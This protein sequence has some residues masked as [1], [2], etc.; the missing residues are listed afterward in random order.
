MSEAPGAQAGQGFADPLF[1]EEDRLG[2]A[3]VA[4]LCNPGEAGALPALE[5][6]LS[7]LAQLY[8]RP[9]R[10]TLVEQIFYLGRKPVRLDI[11]AYKQAQALRAQWSALGFG[12]MIFPRKITAEG[13]KVFLGQVVETLAN[14]QRA[15]LLF[16]QRWGGV[17]IRPMPPA[18]EAADDNTAANDRSM[19]LFC[20]LT[21]L[22]R[23]AVRRVHEGEAP[24][25]LRIKRVL[26]AVI[27]ALK[28]HGGLLLAM[29]NAP[30]SQPES[31][32]HLVNTA[33]LAAL[34]GQR[35]GMSREEVLELSLA[36]LLHD[37]PKAEQDEEQHAYHIEP[38]PVLADREEVE[39]SYLGIVRSMLRTH[40]LNRHSMARMVVLF[41]SQL[42]FSRDDLYAI[43]EEGE[44][45]LS[46][47]SQIISLCSL[48]SLI[49][50]LQTT[51]E[52]ALERTELISLLEYSL[53]RVD[54]A[55]A[56]VFLEVTG[57]YA[58]GVT[59]QLNTSEIGIVL[60]SRPWA[61]TRPVVLIVVDPDRQRV[62]RTVADL[63]RA[64][65]RKVIRTVGSDAL[66]INPVACYKVRGSQD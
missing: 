34:V 20:A 56:R 6:T 30:G 37:L 14:P 5:Q 9:F 63:T 12:E 39:G 13:L 10:L 65:K 19:R 43:T 3:L 45:P 66:G 26:I 7:A 64:R 51:P 44:A 35:L 4:Q 11:L 27:E 58:T 52:T 22:A 41:E 25:I 62:R 61:P 2:C 48:Y 50:S 17:D 23:D 40:P 33:L 28:T 59:V 24:D 15:A 46:F 57:V 32:T 53:R 55:L 31:E 54:P 18:A 29:A 16:E 60:A 36:G 21:F 47:F 8:K 1:T 42:E 49:A 38:W